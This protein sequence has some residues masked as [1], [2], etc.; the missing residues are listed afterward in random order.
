MKRRRPPSQNLLAAVLL[1]AALPL[2]VLPLGSD[3]GHAFEHAYGQAGTFQG[4]LGVSIHEADGDHHV[5]A[6]LEHAERVWHPACGICARL[7]HSQA[8]V[9]R[10]E[11]LGERASTELDLPSER[12]VWVTSTVY[13][14]R[15]PRA[16][17]FA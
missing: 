17:P 2:L 8:L 7:L 3:A 15:Q 5:A 6:R 9:V 12:L 13:S 4:G 11:R 16:P 14:V 10:P 1:V